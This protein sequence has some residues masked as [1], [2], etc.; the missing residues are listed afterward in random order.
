MLPAVDMATAS[1]LDTAGALLG[2]KAHQAGERGSGKGLRFL[3]TTK[4]LKSNICFRV[5]TRLDFDKN[6]FYATTLNI[7]NVRQW[8]I[9]IYL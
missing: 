6:F 7:K 8:Y 4:T 3:N 9:F 2:G 5:W 1:E